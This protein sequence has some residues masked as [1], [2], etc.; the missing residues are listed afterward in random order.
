MLHERIVG[1]G[2]GRLSLAQNLRKQDISF[3]IVERDSEKNICRSFQEALI[4][5]APWHNVH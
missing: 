4:N 1:A 3:E 2:L 5:R